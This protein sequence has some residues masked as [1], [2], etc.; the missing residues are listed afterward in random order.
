MNKPKVTLVEIV[1][2]PELKKMEKVATRAVERVFPGCG[3]VALYRTSDGRVG[4]Q[5][6]VSVAAG[7]RK[8]LDN[9]YR[10]IMKV[11]GIKRGRP[12]G[13]K[14]VQ[15]KLLLPEPVYDA[16]KRAAKESNVTMSHLVAETLK[17]HLPA[18]RT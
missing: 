8:R 18:H 7:D 15:A 12:T 5:M 13:Q 3:P 9:A 11:V 4:F 10:A 17:A 2:D 6:K 16:L 14:T 1:P